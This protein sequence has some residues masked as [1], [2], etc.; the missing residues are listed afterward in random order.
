MSCMTDSAQWYVMV[1]VTSLKCAIIGYG[2]TSVKFDPNPGPCTR[3]RQ[4]CAK[5]WNF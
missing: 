5:K 4:E 3:R 1:A 2:Q